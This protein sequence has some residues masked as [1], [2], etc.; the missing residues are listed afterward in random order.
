MTLP[1]I[2]A[3]SALAL[4]FESTYGTAAAAADGRLVGFNSEGIKG[5][6]ALIDNPTLSGDPN[7]RDA[8]RGKIDAAGPLVAVPNLATAV[9]FGLAG[10]GTRD[11]VDGSTYWTHTL[12]IATGQLPSFTIEKEIPLA[13]ATKYAKILGGVCD[14]FKMSGKQDGFLQFDMG[15]VGAEAVTT[16]ASSSLFTTPDDWT[17][18]LQFEGMQ[19]TAAK[20]KLGGAAI[21]SLLE[22][23]ISVSNN[24]Y[25]DHYVMGGL[26]KRVSAPRG[27]AKVE[28]T[29]K[30][31]LTDVTLYNYLVGGTP[32]GFDMTWDIATHES[33]QI[34]I[35]RMTPDLTTPAIESDGPLMLDA[36]FTASKDSG[37]GS[38]INLIV[39]NNIAG[40]KYAV[41]VA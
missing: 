22:F 1:A 9:L 16:L 39:V 20:C 34:L 17:D 27:R 32:I 18:D 7:P 24:V 2:G 28:V 12:S 19:L 30:A 5:S 36:K 23:S 37:I 38:A 31:I 25:K 21:D 13:A 6:Q 11:S 40:T 35:P 8:A 4:G 41:H 26:G 14:T 3:N 33:L 15:W 29:V 10:L